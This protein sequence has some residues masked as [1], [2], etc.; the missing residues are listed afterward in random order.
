ML[1]ARDTANFA[2]LAT[3]GTPII[4]TFRFDAAP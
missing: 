3:E 2:E 1:F 4:N